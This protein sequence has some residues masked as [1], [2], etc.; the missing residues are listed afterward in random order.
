MFTTGQTQL[1]ILECAPQ[2]MLGMV[3]SGYGPH[4]QH[5]TKREL[6]QRK[7]TRYLSS[8]A[9]RMVVVVVV[10]NGYPLNPRD[11]QFIAALFDHVVDSAL[12]ILYLYPGLK[13]SHEGA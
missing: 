5:R 4:N 11:I 10:A 8:L 6:Q 12:V 2:D 3:S 1:G 7:A 9:R 13:E